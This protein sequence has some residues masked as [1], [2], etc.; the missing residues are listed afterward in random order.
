MELISFSFLFFFPY[1]SLF[2][3]FDASFWTRNR[4]SRYSVPCKFS[5]PFVDFCRREKERVRKK[6]TRVLTRRCT[7]FNYNWKAITSTITRPSSQSSILFFLY[8]LLPSRTFSLSIQLSSSH[9]STFSLKLSSS[10][11]F[12]SR[13]GCTSKGI[14]LSRV[15]LASGNLQRKLIIIYYCKIIFSRERYSFATPLSSFIS[16]LER[17]T[18][19]WR[20]ETKFVMVPRGQ[21]DRS[22]ELL[23]NLITRSS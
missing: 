5:F 17:E 14:K 6:K 11:Y 18:D 1:P 4:L 13:G 19:L 12:F 16:Q 8:A 9:Q 3:F 21:L 10:S 7:S 15:F 22:K 2:H 23:C 20:A